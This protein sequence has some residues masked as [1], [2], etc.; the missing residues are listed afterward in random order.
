MNEA[1]AINRMKAGDISGLQ[2]LVEMHQVQAVQAAALIT[3]DRALA[4]DIVQ[5]AFLRS[6]ERIRQFDQR[7]PFRPW[8]FRMVVN[9]A[10]K[11]AVRRKREVTLDEEGDDSY[12][13]L[14]ERLEAVGEEPEDLLLREEFTHLVRDAI[15]KL[16]PQQRASIIMRYYLGMSEQEMSA[17]M[18]C[19]AGTVKWHLHAAR[20]QLRRLLQ[21]W[22]K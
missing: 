7:R 21:S 3:L 10:I 22:A 14:V 12:R 16:P 15:S 2:V 4:E 1:E 17:E 5:S 6:Y 13:A 18:N 19:A 9:D 11:A 8:F 20:Q